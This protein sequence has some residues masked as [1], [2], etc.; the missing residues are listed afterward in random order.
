MKS[1]TVKTTNAEYHIYKEVV[2]N[3]VDYHYYGGN[4]LIV[5]TIKASECVDESGELMG[6]EYRIFIDIRYNYIKREEIEFSRLDQIT[7]SGER[8]EKAYEKLLAIFNKLPGS[9]K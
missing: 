4:N 2:G 3:C 1:W 6:N 8:A 5:I 9:G 7:I